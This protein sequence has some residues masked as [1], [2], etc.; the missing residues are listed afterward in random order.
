MLSKKVAESISFV[1]LIPQRTVHFKLAWGELLVLPDRL[2]MITNEAPYVRICDFVVKAMTEVSAKSTVTAFGVNRENH[3]KFTNVDERN[4]LGTRLVPPSGWG[5]W[6]AAIQ[7]SMENEKK[8]TPLQGGMTLVQLREPFRDD[9]V[10]GWLD[11]MAAPSTIVPNGG[12]LRSN[13]HHQLPPAQ[14]DDEAG[15]DSLTGSELTS[16][17]LNQLTVRFDSSF[18]KTDSVFKGILAP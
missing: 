6:G 5:K 15:K 14:A 17:L 11:V 7:K 3:Y 18:A 10:M 4:K 9:D 8:G 2:Q 16:H 12:M 13:H 1:T